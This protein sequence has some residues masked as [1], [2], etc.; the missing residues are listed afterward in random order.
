MSEPAAGYPARWEA[1]AVLADGGTVHIRPIR[2]DDA[3]AIEA[4]H[5][6]LSAQTVYLRFF[7]PLPTLAPSLLRRFVEVDYE[8]R[9]A[10]VAELGDEIIGVA[11]Y[12]R[13]PDTDEAEVAFVVEDAHQGRGVGILLLEHLAGAGRENGIARFVADTLAG[14]DRMLRV[15]R[16]A[17]FGD[18]RRFQDGVI[19]VTFPIAPTET[20]VATMNE[21]DRVAT[22]RSVARILAPRSIAVVGAGRGPENLGHRILRNLL[23][24]DFQGPVY[25][26]HPTAAHV[27]SV[28]AFPSVLDIPDE[29]DLAILAVPTEAVLAVVEECGRKRVRGLVVVSDGFAEQGAAGAERQRQLVER[30]HAG[31]MRVIGP[32]SMGVLNTA[33]DVRMNATV[34]PFDVP[35][36]RVGFISQSGALGIT[37][38]EEATRRGV[39]ISTFVAAG[40]KAD[41][42]GNDLIQYWEEDERTSVGL[43]H[44]ESFGNPRTFSRVARRV[45]RRKPLIAVKAGRGGETGGDAAADALFRQTGVI[46]VR[47]TQQLFDVAVALVSQPLPAGRRIGIV[48]NAG[49]PGVLIADAGA[50]LGLALPAISPRTEAALRQAL[51]PAAT[52]GNPV[53]LPAMAGA[54]HYEQA[55]RLLLADEAIDAAVAVFFPSHL[56]SGEDVERAVAAAAA[57]SDKPVLLHVLGGRRST[58]AVGALVPSYEYPESVALALASLVERAEW[59]ARPPGTIPELA[60]TDL[61]AAR[62]SVNAA[63]IEHPGGIELDAATAAQLLACYG[64]P[65]APFCF[66]G[67]PQEARAE[68]DRLGFPVAL[69]ANAPGLAERRDR[70][71]IVLGLTSAAEVGAAYEAMHARLGETMGG[72]VVQRQVEA[73]VETLVRV[74]QDPSFGPVITF[75]LG[76]PAVE[77]LGDHATRVL[78]LTDLDAAELVRSPRGAPLLTGYRG[79]PHADLESIEALLLRVSALVEDIPEI[80][81]LTLD[82]VIAAPGGAVATG[83]AVTVATWEAR[84]ELALRRLS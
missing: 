83:A 26:V 51:P 80:T 35:P 36:G 50:A 69:K 65:V 43:L 11:R 4:L 29:V 17:G 33:R 5:G 46:R 58:G 12:D 8:D 1:D 67:S 82:P 30:A 76:G 49:G 23:A 57:D 38:L 70:G 72:A 78:P 45:S 32:S 56:V 54:G 16:D 74:V 73:G 7:T 61:G 21:R 31:G 27:A 39:G 34:A 20:S 10:L 64:I 53:H 59:L 40:D 37:I 44:I 66:A 41:L 71:A 62:M 68:A 13:L 84:P 63:L 15:F 48:G 42:S 75:G 22:T 2:P 28:R 55:L 3:G 79:A 18:E 81:A 52:A 60:G 19:R 6:R 24:G 25:P 77:L 47:S 9:M 14:N